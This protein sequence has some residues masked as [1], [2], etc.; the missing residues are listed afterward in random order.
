[1]P[2]Q[3]ESDLYEPIKHYL[4]ERGYTVKGEIKGVDLVATHQDRETVLVELK[5]SF[6]L[7]LLFQG[8]DRLAISDRVY[9]AVP[10]SASAANVL[11]QQHKS[12]KKL[13][14]RLGLGLMQVYFGPRTTRVDIL[15]DPGPFQPR[16]NKVKFRALHDEFENRR[17]DPNTGGVTRKRI[18]TAYRQQVLRLA[19][20]VAEQENCSLAEMRE[21]TGVLNA[22]SIVQN[23]HY[24]WFERVS[25]GKYRLTELGVS[26]LNSFSE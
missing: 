16:K 15:V 6:N 26:E 3:F 20:C 23:N 1:M 18:M 9:L 7:K 2:I 11:N 24:G 12:V 19:A 22:A 5:K 14:R 17:G 21:T 8:I 4:E 10:A 25:R 13:C